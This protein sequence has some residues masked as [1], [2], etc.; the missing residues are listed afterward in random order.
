MIDIGDMTGDD[1]FVEDFFTQ[2]NADV[3]AADDGEFD[4]EKEVSY[5]EFTNPINYSDELLY[6]IHLLSGNRDNWKKLSLQFQHL[7]F[8]TIG[9]E[10]EKD[11]AMKQDDKY[12]LSYVKYM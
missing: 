2:W 10:I 5:I 11:S 8:A 4:C 9:M 7:V 12:L 3:G 6:M 1:E